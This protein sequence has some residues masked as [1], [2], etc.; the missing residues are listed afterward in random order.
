MTDIE[1]SR[2]LALAI[3]WTE[4][5][6]DENGCLDPDVIIEGKAFSQEAGVFVWFDEIQWKR[7]D[8]RDPTVI[9]PIAER[10]SVFPQGISNGDYKAAEKL[11]RGINEGWECIRWNYKRLYGEAIGW[12]RY[13]ADTPAKAVAF[14]VIG[15]TK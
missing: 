15:R 7:F 4:D 12:Q 10:Y 1:I 6:R 9:W 2:A 11:G 5:R 13:F 8:Y 3:G 14:A